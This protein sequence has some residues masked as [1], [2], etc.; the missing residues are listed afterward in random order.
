MR[1]PNVTWRIIL[2]DYLF[3]T[4]LRHIR[5]TS[6]Y[7]WSNAY[8]SNG[9]RFLSVVSRFIQEAPLTQ[10]DRE[11]TVSRN[12]V[13]CCIMFDRLHLQ[14]PATGEWLSSSFE[15]TAIAAIWLAIYDFLLVFHCK[16]VS[17][18]HRFRD[19]HTY[20]PLTDPRDGVTQ[21]MLNMPY[22]IM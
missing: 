18:L 11:H 7:F 19:I 13:K 15:V 1:Y 16:D 10:R 3:T 2:Y 6:E 20:L 9:R 21:R 5:S 17:V 8:I 4:E 12:R 22:R 14:R